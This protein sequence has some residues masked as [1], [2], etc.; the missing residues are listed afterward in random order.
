MTSGRNKPLI[1]GELFGMS[2]TTPEGT[3]ETGE[4]EE[5]DL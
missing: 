5:E 2:H 3:L 4:E 1:F